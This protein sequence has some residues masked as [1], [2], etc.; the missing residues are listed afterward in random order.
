VERGTHETLLG[1]NGV[2]ANMYRTQSGWWA[3]IF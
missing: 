3:I 1:L 2:Y